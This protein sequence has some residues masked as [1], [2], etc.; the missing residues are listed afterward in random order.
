MQRIEN[1]YV[2]GVDCIVDYYNIFIKDYRLKLIDETVF[3]H[4]GSKWTFVS[5][6]IANK[7]VIDYIFN[8]YKSDIIVNLV[9]EVGIKTNLEPYIQSNHIGFYNILEAYRHSYDNGEKWIE[10]LIYNSSSSIFRFIKKSLYNIDDKV[11]NPVL[12]YVAT[13]KS[14]ELMDHAYSKLYNIPSIGLRF[15]TV[16]GLVGRLDAVYFGF[17]NKLRNVETIK[18]LKYRNCKCDFTYAGDIVEVVIYVIKNFIIYNIGNSYPEN[19]LEFVD[20]LQ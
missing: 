7:E 8:E 9:V 18:L 4:E 19:L 20:I 11:D 3:K 17:I 16:C 13:K 1:V 6:N 12:L 15:F 5:E 10:Y 14:N 2:I